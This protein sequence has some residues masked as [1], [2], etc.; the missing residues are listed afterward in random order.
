M[1]GEN[2]G[3]VIHTGLNAGNISNNGGWIGGL[4]GK[5]VDDGDFPCHIYS[6]CTNHGTINGMVANVDN[7]IGEGKAVETCLDG[8]TKR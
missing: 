8:H 1:V 7:Q 2:F 4:A 5:N 3:G 6:C